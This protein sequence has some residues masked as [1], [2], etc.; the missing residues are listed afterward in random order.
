M[1]V[2]SSPIVPQSTFL[3]DPQII[4]SHLSRIVK[5]SVC[6][7]GGRTKE[8]EESI[9]ESK[10]MIP[11]RVHLQAWAKSTF[12]INQERAI[13]TGERKHRE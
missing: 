4:L 13:E 2:C 9:D 5:I 10:L 1:L 11:S 12:E 3:V 7:C 8:S 6:R